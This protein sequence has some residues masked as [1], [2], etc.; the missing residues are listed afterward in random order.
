LFIV[1]CSLLIAIT[2]VV[3]SAAPYEKAY[4]RLL[5]SPEGYPTRSLCNS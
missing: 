1:N 4:P 5:G 2:G 3:G